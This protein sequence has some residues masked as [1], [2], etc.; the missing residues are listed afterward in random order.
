MTHGPITKNVSA[1][2]LGLVQIRV[3]AS[4]ANIANIDPV[5]TS[6]NSIGAL[7]ESKFLSSKEF[8]EQ[9][10]GFPLNLDGIVPLKNVSSLDGAYKELTPFNLALSQGINP[11]ADIAAAVV[12]DVSLVSPLGTRDAAK[13]IAVSGSGDWGVI[14]DEWTVVFTGAAAG[15]IFGRVT[16][17]VHDFVALDAAMEP[18]ASAT[19]KYFS[20]PASFFTGTWAANDT[21]VFRT[22]GAVSGTAAYA[23]AHS[24]SIG[25]GNLVAPADLRVE[26]VY[27]FPNGTNTITFIFPRAQ[28]VG[29]LDLAFSESDEAAP[30]I[31]LKSMYAGSEN[32]LGNAVWDSFPQGRIVWA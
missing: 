23:S 7:A 2:A 12:E 3:G 29:D 8:F 13:A 24:G 18:V 10:S 14:D 21:Y 32:A 16:G 27:T 20:I 15:S 5:L 26:G 25:L 4:F 1:R 17:H 9:Y 22:T 30:A 6:A 31:S 19:Y 11:L 28:A